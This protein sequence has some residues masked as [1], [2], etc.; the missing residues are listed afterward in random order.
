MSKHHNAP[1]I[2]R[3]DARVPCHIKE[4]MTIAAAMQGLTQ[5]DFLISAINEL[6]QK[7][8]TEHNVIQLCLEDQKV[9]AEA[10]LNEEEPDMSRFDRLR[11]AADE[12]SR[13][14]G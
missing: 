10:L 4:T 8:I 9:L 5:T 11:Q 14:V 3:I 12:Y 7:V 2:V 1:D 6:A 13:R